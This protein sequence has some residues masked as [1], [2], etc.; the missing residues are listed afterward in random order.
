MYIIV[1]CLQQDVTSYVHHGFEEVKIKR[2]LPRNVD[3]WNGQDKY[4][5]QVQSISEFMNKLD[6]SRYGD[7]TVEA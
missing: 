1:S 4:V 3:I 7:G 2:F 5:V 6:K